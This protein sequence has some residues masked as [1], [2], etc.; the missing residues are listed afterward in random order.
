M[1]FLIFSSF[2]IQASKSLSDAPTLKTSE[3]RGKL[4]GSKMLVF[5][6]VTKVIS[7]KE[8]SQKD[9]SEFEKADG[10]I[11]NF[12][13]TNKGHWF[14]T[15]VF[16]D[17][18][19][20][21]W[22][23]EFQLANI[24]D[25]QFFA[26]H[27]NGEIQSFKAGQ[28]VHYDDLHFKKQNPAFPISIQPGEK[29]QIYIYIQ[30]AGL[31]KLPLY[32]WEELDYHENSS[33]E[34]LVMGIFF[35]IL[36]VMLLYNSFLYFGIKDKSFLYYCI[37]LTGITLTTAVYRGYGDHFLWPDS[38]VWWKNY[39]AFFTSN[40]SLAG[41]ILFMGSFLNLT[42]E[43]RFLYYSARGL[44]IYYIVS[45]IFYAFLPMDIFLGPWAFSGILG[46]VLS[47]VAGIYFLHRGYK[48]ARYYLIAWGVLIFGMF[49]LMLKF[50][51]ILP[52]NFITEYGM[53]CGVALE[54][55]L[56]S[57]ALA[58]RINIL[59]AEKEQLQVSYVNQEKE[60]AETRFHNEMLNLHKE[61]LE[62]DLDKAR[63]IQKGL[64]PSLDKNENIGCVYLPMEQ[65]GGDYFDIIRFEEDKN[66]IGIFISD[67]SGHGVTAALITV[68][69][70]GV[71]RN[72]IK[73]ED[74]DEI[75]NSPKKFLT[76][77]NENLYSFLD[78]NFVSAFYGIIDKTKMEIEFSSA[79]HPPPIVLS[80][81]KS[82]TTTQDTRSVHLDFMNISPQGPP[83]GVFAK[84][85]GHKVTYKNKIIKLQKDTKLLFYSDGFT[86]TIFYDYE[87]METGLD[88]FRHTCVY[89]ILCHALEYSNRDLIA[90]MSKKILETSNGSVLDD[91]CAVAIDV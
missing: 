81:S 53:Q 14:Q 57:I 12:G 23:F 19:I 48:P 40:I 35:G 73:N 1:V 31:A 50:T 90:K 82:K 38:S 68:M 80:E 55:L 60:V 11:P 66:K 79:A 87:N 76:L 27:Q 30:D 78:G 88:S 91:I 74:S 26:I 46:G 33:I 42:K 63:R 71:I 10:D 84:S 22:V 2:P 32:L 7:F 18:D 72:A 83:L 29:A 43:T 59:R 56:L 13:I 5:S 9:T 28:K 39:S 64:I 67:V 4:V 75:L 51:G 85:V 15:Q 17:T 52:I 44:L 62:K 37:Y 58:D 89:G 24:D 70:N 69:I 8:I 86:D 54:A 45:S 41:T 36:L 21:D 6:E 61:L 47:I 20:T 25:V 49:A 34:T 77:L 65:I 16:N 3:Y